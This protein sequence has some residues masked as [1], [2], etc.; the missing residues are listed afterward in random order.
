M[1][2]IFVV[3]LAGMAS[4]EI[5]ESGDA[6]MEIVEHSGDTCRRRGNARKF[7]A[8]RVEIAEIKRVTIRTE[9]VGVF[10]LFFQGW[11]T[12]ST[13]RKRSFKKQKTRK[14]SGS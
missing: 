6:E 5:Q 4:F 9:K 7:P 13:K 2:I 3:L 11:R 1:F 8:V 10:Y 14:N 12:V